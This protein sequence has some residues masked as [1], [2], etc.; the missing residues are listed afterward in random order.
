MSRKNPSKK[1]RHVQGGDSGG[2]AAEP[3]GARSTGAAPNDA[4][5]RSGDAAGWPGW[6]APV[7]YALVTLILFREFVF[8]GDMLLGMDT[9]G[10]GYVAREFYATALRTFGFPYWNPYILGGTP[11]LESLAGGDSLY[12]TSLLLL[13]MEPHRALGWKLVLHVFLA[14]VFMYAWI[15]ALGMG[16][17][18]AFLAGLAYLMAP[19]LVTLVYPGHDGKMFVTAL[20]PLAFWMLEGSFTRGPRWLLGLALVIGV[21]LLSTHFQMAYFLFGA[22]GVYGAY[23]A[24]EMGR[25]GQW[26]RAGVRFGLFMVAAVLGAAVA[27]IQF[28][29]AVEYVTSD[30]RRTATTTAAS[31]AENIAYSSSWS[32]HPEEVMALAVPEFVGSDIANGPAW[33]QN[34]YWGRNAFKHNHEYFG[35][36]VL[37]LA[38][39]AF[40]SGR[41]QGAH[42]WFFL[43]LGTTALLYALGGNTPVWRVFYEVVPG[44]SLFR[45][46]SIA[47]FLVAFSFIT[48]AAMGVDRAVA[49]FDAGEA[50][51]GRLMRRLW[52]GTAVMGALLLL[53]ASGI[54]FSLWTGVLYS[55]IVE[56]RA[57]ILEA[58]RPGIVSGLLTA[59]LTA[60]AVAGAWFL[61]SRE[62]LTTRTLTVVLALVLAFD[63]GRVD[64]P[65][66]QTIDFERWAS[67]DRS[68]A[69][70]A[71]RVDERQPFR[72]LSMNRSSQ[73]VKPALYGIELVGGHHPN[74]L[75]RYRKL[76]GMEGSG[77]PNHLFQS[78]QLMR[79]LNVRYLLW[80]VAQMGAPFDGQEPLASDLL[81]DGR[82][83]QGVYPFPG[84]PRARLAGGPMVLDD[85]RAME[86][87][88]S[89]GFSPETQVVLSEA[90]PGEIT[91]AAVEGSVTW[92]SRNPNEAT[93]SVDASEAA[94]LVVADNWTDAWRASVNGEP[95]PVLRAYTTLRAIPVPAG[96]SEVRMWY[97]ASGLRTALWIS[98]AALTALLAGWTALTLGGRREGREQAAQANG[99]G[100]LDPE[101]PMAA[102]SDSGV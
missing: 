101:A 92:I 70:L 75:A 21:I 37:M 5:A 99:A 100:D 46:P 56:G 42:R 51:V 23:R 45:V 69:Y 97:D 38:L 53:G 61:R 19:M 64:A 36:A 84:L 91:A 10:L 12:P 25:G 94:L 31:D 34:T 13:I 93:L 28:L 80:P 40:G 9:L 89:P 3:R 96:Q 6:L 78:A 66:I 85:D 47:I 29:P 4:S 43:A 77:L 79:L 68:T 71:E 98:L 22:M 50:E 52:V 88:L 62:V 17:P 76:I 48:L 7:A 86:H 1:Q 18:A 74:D 44:V 39:L 55:G 20:T 26:R 60:G 72:V 16:R 67:P 83:L 90:A 73:D 35:L 11:F 57:A 59:T 14:G 8:S 32:L 87:M 41:R 54:L 81:P 30:S 24:V 2:G 102:S 49:A 58:A 95:A 27:A 82:V 63:A 65:F 15:R 33:T